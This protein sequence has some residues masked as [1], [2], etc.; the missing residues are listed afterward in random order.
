M[1]M[2]NTSLSDSALIAVHL[3][4]VL[5]LWVATVILFFI[6]WRRFQQSY[7]N[8]DAP[9][10]IVYAFISAFASSCGFLAVH[11]LIVYA[12]S[13]HAG[14]D[15]V[16][17]CYWHQDPV[18]FT[19]TEIYTSQTPCELDACNCVPAIL[20]E[21]P[22]CTQLLEARTRYVCL[23]EHYCCDV[24]PT[25]ECSE[26]GNATCGIV[27]NEAW[28]YELK[29]VFQ[30]PSTLEVTNYTTTGEC[31]G[32]D[33]CYDEVH[34]LYA[35]FNGTFSLFVGGSPDSFQTAQD[36]PGELTPWLIAGITIG[37]VFLMCLAGM[38]G[39]VVYMVYRL[40]YKRHLG[41]TNSSCPKPQ[42]GRP[43]I[44]SKPDTE[45]EPVLEM[46]EIPVH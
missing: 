38:L 7:L 42:S 21:L 8:V 20:T 19:V 3:A 41:T 15:W 29:A 36:F 5:L 6:L 4:P 16:D 1:T 27:C 12:P 44:L 14:Q 22:E 31:E 9:F 11:V 23:E 2:C 26:Y 46:T 10:P 39:I 43:K 18:Q 13:V 32:V 35:R 33:M 45:E 24:E 34:T 28:Y 40:A 25:P 17:H 30:F 37:T